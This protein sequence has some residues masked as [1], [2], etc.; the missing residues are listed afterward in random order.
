M[1]H[2][3]ITM[4]TRHYC[5]G[6]EIHSAPH[7]KVFSACDIDLLGRLHLQTRNRCHLLSL[8]PCLSCYTRL[9]GFWVVLFVIYS[10]SPPV[11][12]ST[13]S[14]SIEFIFW[15][16]ARS[17]QLVLGSLRWSDFPCLALSWS[18]SRGREGVI[19]GALLPVP[20][21]IALTDLQVLGASRTEVLCFPTP[22]QHGL[23]SACN[24]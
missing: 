8:F 23:L 24:C 6:T 3:T 16:E 12:S 4:T 9:H 2:G 21:L 14:I 18:L 11:C 7:S 5:W 1:D 10:Y 19:S 13:A 22:T 15:E 20:L 17:S